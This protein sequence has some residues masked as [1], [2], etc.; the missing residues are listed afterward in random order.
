MFN[1]G[2]EVSNSARDWYAG[3]LGDTNSVF[4][5]ADVTGGTTPFVV[6]TAGRVGI[7]TAHPIEA[8]DVH[9]RIAVNANVG[10][11]ARIDLYGNAGLSGPS[12]GHSTYLAMYDTNAITSA[13][14]VALLRAG[15]VKDFGTGYLELLTEKNGSLVSGLYIENGNVGIGTTTPAASLHVASSGSV[16]SPTNGE[17]LPDTPTS[18]APRPA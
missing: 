4:A 2:I 12:A 14:S 5:I 17:T 8:L 15:L 16:A 9:G 11:E 3:V 1:A 18:P 6:D 7:G 13:V 10:K